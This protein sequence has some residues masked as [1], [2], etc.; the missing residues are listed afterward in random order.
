LVCEVDPGTAAW[1]SR[2]IEGWVTRD[3][4]ALLHPLQPVAFSR[5]V[6]QESLPTIEIDDSRTFQPIEGFGF[7]LTGG[8]AYLLVGL[9]TADRADLLQELFGLTDASVGLSCLRLSIGASDLGRKDFSYWGLRRGT[10]A[11]DLARFSLCAGD[12][13]VVPVL[14]QILR[15][16]PAVKIIASP[17]SA[18]PWM[19]SNGSYV[20]GRLKPEHYSEYARYFVKYVETMRGHGIHVSAVTPQ[21][22]PLNAKNEPSMVM[23]ATEQ[24]D[25][26]K[27]YLGPELRKAAPE[28]EILCWDHNC[29]VPEYPLTVLGDAEARAYVAGVAWHMYNGSAETMSQVRA[30]YPAQKVHFTEQ[31]V[32]AE[33]DFMGALRWHTKNIIIGTLRNWSRTALEW[34]LASDPRYALHTRM[35]A[36]GALGG[37]TIAATIKHRRGVGGASGGVTIGATIKRNPG[38]YLMAHSARFI[39]PGSVRVYSSEVDRLP[40]VTCL[41]PDSRMVMV[42]MNDGDDPR[43][44][45]V[46]HRGAWATLELGTGDVA[47]LRWN[48][49]P[50]VA[51]SAPPTAI[52]T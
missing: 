24:A 12:R 50:A 7:S 39:R 18:P 49:G 22:E 51:Q 52:A 1:Q 43:R 37:V 28:T 15:I 13:E 42:V 40:N 27:G 47:T 14:Q 6:P 10:A 17:W 20:A 9:S 30:Q 5:S 41:T 21:N 23:T 2:V 4:N 33:D 34:N 16:N 32:S 44:F 8:S 29:D 11:P 38:Y 26:I 3:A 31:W 25:F 35:G 19:K 36:V 45:R 46:Q 48:V